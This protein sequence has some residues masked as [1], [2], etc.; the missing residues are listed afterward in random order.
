MICGG[1][2]GLRRLEIVAGVYDARTGGFVADGAVYAAGLVVTNLVS[3][4]IKATFYNR[5]GDVLS[6]QTAT[7][8]VDPANA[9]QPPARR[10][11]EVFFG[12]I[13]ASATDPSTWPHRIRLEDRDAGEWGLDDFG[14]ALAP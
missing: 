5:A 10:G 6:S 2:G 1:A 11:A 8:V 13:A 7:G 12:H 9:D 14:F 3:G 4:E